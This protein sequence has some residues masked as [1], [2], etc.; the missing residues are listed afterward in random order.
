[1]LALAL[2][3][4]L[5]L[6]CGAPGSA[7]AQT[8]GQEISRAEYAG[9]LRAMWLGEAIANWTGLT[10]EGVKEGAPF[11]TDADWGLD[12]DVDW[13]SNDVIEFVLQDPWLADDDTDIEYVYLHLLDRHA[14][15][16][17]TPAQIADGW[18]EHVNEYIWVSNLQA[19]SLMEQGVLPPMTGNI[20]ANADSLQIDA[21]LTTEL[22]GALAPGMP[23]QALRLAN[24]P[25]LTTASG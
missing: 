20:A 16:L 14:T 1:V 2:V 13:K 18:R 9:R 15:N 17:L 24:L 25:I 21:Q 19:R 11:Y 3:S 8:G 5:V 22:F 12:Q 6:A 4:G 23:D 7:L 10:T